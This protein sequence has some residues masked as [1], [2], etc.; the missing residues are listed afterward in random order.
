MVE[1][2]PKVQTTAYWFPTKASG[3]RLLSMLTEFSINDHPGVGEPNLAEIVW[4]SG[5]VERA[6]ALFPAIVPEMTR[7]EARRLLQP[8]P[9]GRYT[10][11]Y[12]RS[13]GILNMFTPSWGEPED[14]VWADV[15]AGWQAQTFGSAGDRQAALRALEQQWNTTPHPFFAGL[16]PAQVMVGGGQQEAKLAREF[17]ER[18]TEMFDGRPFD[19]EGHSLADTLM[20]LRGWECRPRGDGQRPRGIIVAERNELLALRDRIL[21]QAQESQ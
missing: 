15:V 9:Q 7:R 8:W 11:A 18:L 10:T 5:D 16:T 19:S 14:E 20:V 1:N 21:K 6:I 3:E 2:N 12:H 4:S 13:G 17:L